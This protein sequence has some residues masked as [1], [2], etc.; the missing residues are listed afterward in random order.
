MLNLKKNLILI[1][2]AR[3]QSFEKQTNKKN[4][5][6]LFTKVKPCWV[7]WITGWVTTWEI[8]MLYS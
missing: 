3:A 2:T 7:G 5:T 4:G 6:H 1:N 8:F